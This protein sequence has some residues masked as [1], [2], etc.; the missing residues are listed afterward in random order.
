MTINSDNDIFP[1]AFVDQVHAYLETHQQRYGKKYQDYFVD[2]TTKNST[3][4]VGLSDFPRSFAQVC[5]TAGKMCGLLSFTYSNDTVSVLLDAVK[6]AFEKCVSEDQHTLKTLFG[7]KT[8]EN[9]TES[10]LLEIGL[11]DKVDG[12]IS[13][14]SPGELLLRY[15][16]L[17][18]I[19]A[20]EHQGWHR[21]ADSLPEHIYQWVTLEK[22]PQNEDLLPSE[23]YTT[24]YVVKSKKSGD[25]GKL[26]IITEAN[27]ETI[28]NEMTDHYFLQQLEKTLRKYFD[29]RCNQFFKL[30]TKKSEPSK[31][32]YND[33]YN[34]LLSEKNDSLKIN[35]IILRL[36]A[37]CQQI[38]RLPANEQLKTRRLINMLTEAG[39]MSLDILRS[40]AYP[41]SAR[42]QF[43]PV[44]TSDAHPA[45]HK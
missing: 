28:S 17:K 7:G 31:Q 20:G 37:E 39:F 25:H 18:T 33:L 44:E 1:Q 19:Y 4:F 12:P 8:S 43:D 35:N 22:K 24:K 41:P 45:P 42:A 30:F 32:L 38:Q 11:Y 27:K 10:D 3:L 15:E 13:K 23:L 14:K 6:N 40:A 2:T 16:N 26:R 29:D 34:I 21:E 9:I 36:N 5:C